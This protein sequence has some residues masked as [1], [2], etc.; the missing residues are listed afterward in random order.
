MATSSHV[1]KDG[2]H[3]IRTAIVKK[4]MIRANLMSLS[5]IEPELWA[6]KVYIAGTGI[7]DVFNSCN[8][9][10]DPITMT[11]L[12]HIACIYTACANMNFVC[13]G[14]RKLLFDT[15]TY[16][17]TYTQNRPK[18]Q[19]MPLS[20]WSTINQSINQSKYF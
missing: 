14:F 7:L 12:T 2:G 18:L 10:L 17:H 20:G 15:H 8:L 9:D 13:Q 4:P 11:N 1:K 3:T 19:T 6:I 16:I 5:L